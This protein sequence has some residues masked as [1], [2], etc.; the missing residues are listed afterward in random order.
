MCKICNSILF[1]CGLVNREGLRFIGN[2]VT[3]IVHGPNYSKNVE[4]KW[5]PWTGIEI[6]A[7][8]SLSISDFNRSIC[9]KKKKSTMGATEGGMEGGERIAFISV[10]Q[11]RA[12]EM[13]WDCANLPRASLTG[14]RTQ[15]D[16]RSHWSTA[17][18]A[19][20]RAGGVDMPGKRNVKM[21]GRLWES[22]C[23][24]LNINNNYSCF[25]FLITATSWSQS[26]WF[27]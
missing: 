13:W 8:W 4:P 23:Q 10:Q 12:E 21:P 19:G 16:A 5:G 11:G 3:H 27:V 25:E 1:K 20:V 18:F 7:A 14:V 24:I 17:A 2:T 26:V 9:E 6:S 22:W 15:P